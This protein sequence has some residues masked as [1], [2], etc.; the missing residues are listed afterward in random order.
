MA[1]RWVATLVTLLIG[2]AITE[3]LVHQSAEDQRAT[4]DRSART[5][6][7]QMTA[8]IH[9]NLGPMVLLNHNLENYISTENGPVDPDH[10]LAL[11]NRALA[12]DPTLAE[13]ALA[14]GNRITDVVPLEGNEG[15]VGVDL[16]T[17]AD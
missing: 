13:I 5:F 14:P 12:L 1:V 16:R 7:K 9:E 17:I 6:A 2:I 8:R 15:A 11:M 3:V 10:T 4:S